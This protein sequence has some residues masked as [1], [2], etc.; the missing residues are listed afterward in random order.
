VACCSIKEQHMGRKGYAVEFRRRALELVAAGGPIIDVARDVGI[1]S[2][3]MYRWQRQDRID[4]GLEREATSAE[5]VELAAAKRRIVQL[6]AEL[7]TANKAVE[8]LAEATDP[9][10]GSRRAACPCDGR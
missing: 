6:E 1:S 7:A 3:S 4:E 8:L 9:K 2:Q 10:G 5:A